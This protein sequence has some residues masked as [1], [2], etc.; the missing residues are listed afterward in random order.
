MRIQNVR[1]VKE[2]V[3]PQLVRVFDETLEDFNQERRDGIVMTAANVGET[4]FF[5]AHATKV[6]TS[7]LALK[8]KYLSAGNDTGHHPPSNSEHASWMD[9]PEA[10]FGLSLFSICLASGAYAHIGHEIQQIKASLRSRRAKLL[11]ELAPAIADQYHE[12][13]QQPDVPAP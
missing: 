2:T 13:T 9:A 6:A 5:G 12:R 8:E 7:S 3:D 4:I 1:I 10:D 11:G